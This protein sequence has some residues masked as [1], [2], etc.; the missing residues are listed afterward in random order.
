MSNLHHLRWI[1]N[2]NCPFGV[3]GSAKLVEEYNE[4]ER[5]HSNKNMQSLIDEMNHL[6]VKRN[7]YIT[8]EAWVELFEKHT[9]INQ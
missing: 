8:K 2:P 6:A 7:F 9:G 3:S 5:K 1:P 4:L